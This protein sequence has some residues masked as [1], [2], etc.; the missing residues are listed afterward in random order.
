MIGRSLAAGLCVVLALV[1]ALLAQT[2]WIAAGALDAERFAD[3]AV[4]ALRAPE[5]REAIATQIREASGIPAAGPAAD[6]LDQ[7]VGAVVADPA[8]AP[9][10]APGLARAHRSYLRGDGARLD[11]EP[12]RAEVAARAGAVDPALAAAVPPPGAVGAVTLAESPELIG[13]GRLAD[14]GDQATPLTL[15]LAAASLILLLLALAL[16]RRPAATAVLAGLGYLGL[17][18]LALVARE[19]VPP[20]AGEAVAGGGV[21]GAAVERLGE[22]VV[23]GATLAAAVTALAGAVLV[24]G[25]GVA[26][27]GRSSRRR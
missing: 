5:G 13:L 23:S 17:A 2:V 19:V 26:T 6:V 22:S 14:V 12:V 16:S 11:L 21:A 15:L 8:F 3:A 25:A 9:L 10:V 27:A 1:A 24:L 7:A 4:T 18:A 20:A